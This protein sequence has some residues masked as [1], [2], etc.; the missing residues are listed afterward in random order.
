M[1]FRHL[2]RNRAFALLNLLGLT[3]GLSAA[4]LIFLYVR[5]EWSYDDFHKNA[6]RL[7]RVQNDRIYADRHDRSSGCPP[8]AGPELAKAYSA[9]IRSARLMTL[10]YDTNLVAYQRRSSPGS[11]EEISP[12]DPA[13]A[14]SRSP[15]RDGPSIALTQEKVFYAEGAFL[16]MFSFPLLSGSAETALEEP[17]TAV[18]TAT[19]AGRYFQGENPVGKVITVTNQDGRVPYMITAV[20]AD[21]PENTHIKF[22]LLLSYPTLVGLYPQAAHNWGWNMFNTYIELSPG[23]DPGRLEA[24]FPAFIDRQR[25]HSDDYR[26]VFR[27]QPVRS[28]H[29]HSHLR[30]EPEVNGDARTVNLMV[31]VGAFILIIAWVNHINL[32][33]ARSMR[34]A[35]EV[36]LRKILGSRRA[37]LLRRFLFESL[38]LNGAAVALSLGLAAA[39]LPTFGRILGK[40]VPLPTGLFWLWP[41]IAL[42][43]GAFL[44]GLYPAHLLS[45]FQPASVLKGSFIR[46]ARGTV[47]RRG[48]VVFQFALSITL[49]IATLVVAR[50]LNYMRTR[51]LGIDIDQTLVLR[52]PRVDSSFVPRKERLHRELKALPAFQN[53]TVCSEVPGQESS[54]VASGFRPAEAPP[55]SAIQAYIMTVDENYFDFFGIRMLAGRGFSRERPT[56]SEKIIINREAALRFGFSNPEEAIQRVIHFGGLGDT[57]HEIIGVVNDFHQRSLKTSIKPQVFQ[58]RP[59]GSRIAIRLEPGGMKSSLGFVKSAYEKIFIET[60]FEYFFL[61]EFFDNQ[62][63]SEMRF[64]RIF[65]IFTGL[66]ILVACLGLFGLT[67][68]TTEQRIREIGIRKV[69]GASSLGLALL[70]SRDFLLWVAVANLIAWPLAWYAMTGWLKRFAYHMRLGGEVFLLAGIL[71]LGIALLTVAA[72]SLKAALADPADTLRFE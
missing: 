57:D 66:A 3:I 11:E 4:L 71:A 7:Y 28:I 47:L 12:S 36:G 10:R 30:H 44:S 6:A 29:L 43:T 64:G 72:Q 53:L 51:S 70:M 15:G 40:P 59:F 22:E 38:F 31:L 25:I 49:I 45:S 62:Y 16:R 60:G 21:P 58:Y 24:L 63:Q 18:I 65:G 13:P 27:L 50:Q 9:I 34:R 55:E 69:L 26:R 2:S 5:F 17:N 61:D 37:L 56:D 39:L 8:A 68:S 14:A 46:S 20:A 52:I 42:V 33:T 23:T 19:T 32:A 48:L 35:R 67:L 1:T 41:G 54:G